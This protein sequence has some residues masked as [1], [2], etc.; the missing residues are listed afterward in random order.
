MSERA[1]T[2]PALDAAGGGS[3]ISTRTRGQAAG[4]DCVAGDRFSAADI[5]LLVTVDVATR[6][7]E[8]PIPDD[9]VALKSWYAVSSSRPGAAA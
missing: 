5:T 8:M 1:G 4:V 9:T 7:L 2:R 6:A 3:R